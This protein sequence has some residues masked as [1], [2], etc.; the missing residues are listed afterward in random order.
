MFGGN[1]DLPV[2]T[3]DGNVPTLNA[4]KA[5]VKQPLNVADIEQKIQQTMEKRFGQATDQDRSTQRDA[6]VDQ[7]VINN[8][9]NDLS[10]AST[11]HGPLRNDPWLR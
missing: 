1:G 6:D 9:Q 10:G 5:G 4:L 11:W 3:I 8:I 2:S 7:L